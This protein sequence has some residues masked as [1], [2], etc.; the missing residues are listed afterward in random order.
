MDSE[1]NE[2]GRNES[3]AAQFGEPNGD[4]RTTGLRLVAPDQGSPL[5]KDQFDASKVEFMTLTQLR[6]WLTKYKLKSS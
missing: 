3:P 2:V 6:E 1:R 4:L 5:Q